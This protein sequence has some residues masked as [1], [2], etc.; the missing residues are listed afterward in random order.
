MEP[1]QRKVAIGFPAIAL[2]AM[3]VLQGRELLDT[4]HA[5]VRETLT[6]RREVLPSLAKLLVE[7]EVV[8]RRVLT[9]APRV[10]GGLAMG[11]RGC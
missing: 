3:F 8:S 7:N 2:I 5:R 1:K 9:G 4:A 11:G 10:H 6:A